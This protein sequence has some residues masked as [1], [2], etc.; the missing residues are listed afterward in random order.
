MLP[1]QLD[2]L[3]PVA[4]LTDDGVTLLLQHLLEVEAD[5]GLVLGDD[6]AGR[7]RR[8]VRLVVVDGVY[9]LG[10]LGGGHGAP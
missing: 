8:D 9:G 10:R 7:Q 6:D 1:G 4:R 5:E 2:G 3:L